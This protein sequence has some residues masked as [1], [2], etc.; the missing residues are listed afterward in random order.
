VNR[1]IQELALEAGYIPIHNADFAN[2]LDE[3]FH[4]KFAEL[5]IKECA[6]VCYQHSENAGGADTAFGYGYKDCGDDIK[7]IFGV[8]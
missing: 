7:R 4:Q 3:T 6:D 1:R 5:I 2:S 8:E